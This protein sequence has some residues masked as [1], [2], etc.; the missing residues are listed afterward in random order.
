MENVLETVLL[1]LFGDATSPREEYL[2]LQLMQQTIQHEMAPHKVI[3]HTHLHVHTL[4]KKDNRTRSL[5][6]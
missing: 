3:A 6:S 4:R 5:A 2:L 1:T